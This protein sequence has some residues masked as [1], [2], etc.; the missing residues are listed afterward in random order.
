MWSTYKLPGELDKWKLGLG[1]TAQSNNGRS[2]TIRPY[3]PVTGQYDGAAED[4][5]FIQAGYAIWSS[6]VEYK[7]DEH[8]AAVV[9]ANNIF[10][11][12]TIRPSAP[13]PTATSMAN[14]VISP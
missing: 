8:W 11:K 9:N 1:V 13:Q 5:K 6:S 2:G 3:N 7:I 12:S 4:F 10:D 14:R